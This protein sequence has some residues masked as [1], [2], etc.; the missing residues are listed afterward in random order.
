MFQMFSRSNEILFVQLYLL[1]PQFESPFT[2]AT[3]LYLYKEL[4]TLH[5]PA[6]SDDAF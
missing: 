1:L 5:I 2:E 6:M 3:Q 4:L